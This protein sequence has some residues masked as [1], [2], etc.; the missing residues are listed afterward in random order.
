MQGR[1][2][3]LAR[4]PSAPLAPCTTRIQSAMAPDA[5]ADR[6][7][8]SRRL[9]VPHRSATVCRRAP[10]SSPSPSA[11]QHAPQSDRP[12][13]V[14]SPAPKLG[15]RG[16]EH[17]HSGQ[18]GVSSWP[19]R[20]PVLCARRVAR[21][22]LSQNG[23]R[24]GAAYCPNVTSFPARTLEALL[25]ASRSKARG[26]SLK[27]PRPAVAFRA[28]RWAGNGLCAEAW[29]SQLRQHRWRVPRRRAPPTVLPDAATAF[30]ASGHRHCAIRVKAVGVAT[31]LQHPA[32]LS[33]EH[34]CTRP[35][36]RVDNTMH[37]GGH[38]PDRL[39]R[40][41]A[42]KLA[43]GQLAWQNGVSVQARLLD[44]MVPPFEGGR[45]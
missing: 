13:A 34:V 6:L 20:P 3:W 39:G 26:R 23:N 30:G 28:V 2:R 38:R 10:R 40:A 5:S 44:L 1:S 9:L 15:C 12:I 17:A 25:D 8:R 33:N 7:S 31:V 27:R 35:L 37:H 29:S 18:I 41:P 24:G 19:S 11:A 36:L 21:R 4:R 43:C 22:T 42:R 14:R 32:P 16:D 45:T